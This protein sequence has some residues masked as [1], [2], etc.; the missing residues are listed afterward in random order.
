MRSPRYVRSVLN[1]SPQILT[2]RR[3]P[4]PRQILILQ[5]HQPKFG[6]QFNR[7]LQPDLGIVQ[8]PQLALVASQVV[9][10]HRDVWQVLYRIDPVVL[11]NVNIFPTKQ[12]K[13]VLPFTLSFLLAFLLGFIAEILACDL[14]IHAAATLNGKPL[15]PATKL[16]FDGFGQWENESILCM[17]LIPWTLLLLHSLLAPREMS[18]VDRSIRQLY[19]FLS[20]GLIEAFLFVFFIFHSCWPWIPHYITGLGLKVPASAYIPNF[21]LLLVFL[22]IVVIAATKNGLLRRRIKKEVTHS[23]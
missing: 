12:M 21:V 22:V 17:F 23:K 8:I 13:K 3:P 11:G 10:E 7:P 9:V 15:P 2:T 19:G 4:Q 14:R 16:I 5:R 6:I 20:F 1:S 18:F